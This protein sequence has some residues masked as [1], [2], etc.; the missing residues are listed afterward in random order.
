[1]AGVLFLAL[2]IEFGLCTVW[3][4]YRQTGRMWPATALSLARGS[5]Q[6]KTAYLKFVEIH[7]LL[8]LSH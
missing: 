3:C 7:L 4:D 6:K 1:M 8:H 2:T 5:I